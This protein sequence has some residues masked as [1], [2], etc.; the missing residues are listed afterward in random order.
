MNLPVLRLNA[1]G[2]ENV[3]YKLYENARHECLNETNR[4]EVIID[5]VAFCNKI[6]G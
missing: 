3:S 6:T 5:I 4:S 1:A 2:I